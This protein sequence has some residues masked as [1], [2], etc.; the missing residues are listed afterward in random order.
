MSFRHRK[1]VTTWTGTSDE[2]PEQGSGW[3]AVEED[4]LDEQV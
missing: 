2:M 1:Y 4:I 3:V